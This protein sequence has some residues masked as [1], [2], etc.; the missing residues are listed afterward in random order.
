MRSGTGDSAKEP[1]KRD[2]H[3]RP[4]ALRIHKKGLH[5]RK[6]DLRGFRLRVR[7]KTRPKS[8]KKETYM[9]SK[10]TCI[11]AKEASK[12]AKDTYVALDAERHI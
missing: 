9:S 6:R 7:Q 8:P 5:I 11:S 12:F 2:L 3:N 1:Y 4:K 10:E